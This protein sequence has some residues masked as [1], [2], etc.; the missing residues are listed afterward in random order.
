MGKEV[1]TKVIHKNVGAL[2]AG[3][4]DRSSTEYVAPENMYI[5]GCS[6]GKAGNAS[7]NQGIMSIARGGTYKEMGSY[8]D[9]EQFISDDGFM[10][11]W[12][13]FGADGTEISQECDKTIMLPDDSYFFL[14]QGERLYM[15]LSAKNN[16]ATV[17][18]SYGGSAALY[19]TK[20]KP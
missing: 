12:S 19:Y 13:H 7:G 20:T 10:F 11:H 8:T 16:H 15:H 4:T 9:G 1:Y 6:F 2:A 14:E 18:Y 3:V 5:V 17:E